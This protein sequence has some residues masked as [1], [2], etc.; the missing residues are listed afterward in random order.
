MEIVAKR[1][2]GRK[3]QTQN[4]SFLFRAHSAVEVFTLVPGNRSP[5]VSSVEVG[6]VDVRAERRGAG[7]RT[8]DRGL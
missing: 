1:I 4:G 5:V 7:V 3:R 2:T 8:S 6:P